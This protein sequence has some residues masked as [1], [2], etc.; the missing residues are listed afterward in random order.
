MNPLLLDLR[1]SFRALLRAPGFLAALVLSLA[2]GVGA[3]T[4]VF[5][6]LRASLQGN[7]QWRS[8][9]RLVIVGRQDAET[10]QLKDQLPISW[11]RLEHWRQAHDGLERLD[12]Y[13]WG[14]SRLLGMGAPRMLDSVRVTDGFFTTLGG[15]P[16]MGRLLQAG[17]ADVAVLSHDAWREVFHGDRQ[18]VGRSLALDGRTFTVVGV[19]PRGATWQGA[20]L[21][22]PLRP[23][24]EE[25][26]GQDN[27]IYTVGRLPAGGTLEGARLALAAM[28]ARLAQVD[29]P[30][31]Q[32]LAV[33]R[34]LQEVWFANFRASQNFL[35]L[36]ALFILGLAGL[37]VAVLLLGRGTAR[38]SE[39]GLREALGARRFH[40]YLPL[41]TE[42]LV[43]AVPGILLAFLFARWAQDLLAGFVPDGL[44]AFHV[45]GWAELGFATVLALGLVALSAVLPV[46]LLVRATPSLRL[47]G[48]RSTSD[49]RRR[50]LS[51]GLVALQVACALALLSGFALVYSGLRHLMHSPAGIDGRRCLVARVD[52]DLPSAADALRVG[53]QVRQVL[54]RLQGL[55]GVAS[56]SA[57]NLAP[58]L[59]GGWNGTVSVPG[60]EQ[61]AFTWLRTATPGYFQAMGIPFL[62][63][64]DFGNADLAE[65]AT[66]VI[67]SASFARDYFHGLEPLGRVVQ[68]EGNLQVVGV[69]GDVAVSSLGEEENRQT[70]YLPRPFF[71]THVDLVVEAKGAPAPLVAAVRQVLQEAWPELPLGR[72]APIAALQER[73]LRDQARQV[74]LYGVLAGLALA[75]TAAGLFGVLSRDVQERRRELGIRMALGATPESVVAM[76]LRQGLLVVGTGVLL[77]LAGGAGMGYLLRD[78]LGRNPSQDPASHLLA[79]ALLLVTA[80]LAMLLPAL[81]AARVDP[82]E[83]LRQD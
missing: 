62:A 61:P 72:I 22:L 82:M 27:W 70:L 12:G 3:N 11:P 78:D 59:N 31:R 36:A 8:P 50:W 44:G 7:L 71:G 49:P 23:K 74:L 32:V 56:A 16:L 37:N 43:A 20:E 65:H 79:V 73:T 24:P 35:G 64:R 33:P 77:G 80:L 40:L 55:P 18:I 26:S 60:H 46:L 42:A 17:D 14:T 75:I 69:V 68:R 21:F 6:V 1:Q 54:Q 63:G 58:G 57:T 81:H 39:L 13:G 19:L 47:S 51:H 28:S 10:P 25:Q 76:I 83:A 52:L 9:E 53:A 48:G 45:T 30:D 67:V 66:S 29:N 2:L 38:A 34:A 15:R 5:S 4:A 41:L